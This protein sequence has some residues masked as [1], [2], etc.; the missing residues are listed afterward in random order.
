MYNKH[1]PSEYQKYLVHALSSSRRTRR[2]GPSLCPK[3]WTDSSPS[4]QCVLEDEDEDVLMGLCVCSTALK[5]YFVHAACGGKRTPVG[6]S[7]LEW[8]SAPLPPLRLRLRVWRTSS[9]LRSGQSLRPKCTDT[10]TQSQRRKRSAT[11][12]GLNNHIQVTRHTGGGSSLSGARTMRSQ[13]PCSLYICTLG[14][15]LLRQPTLT[16]CAHS[17]FMNELT[18]F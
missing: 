2:R 11:G 13:V 4:P 12:F 6:M 9:P 1:S 10:L 8:M 7:K 16:L 18:L 15:G 3:W 5:I 14:R 17:N